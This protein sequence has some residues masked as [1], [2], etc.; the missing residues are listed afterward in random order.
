M[1]IAVAIAAVLDPKWPIELDGEGRPHVRPDR[2]ILS[3]FDESALEIALRLR[4]LD[5]ERVSISAIVTAEKIARAIAAFRIEDIAIL[6]LPF[7]ATCDA[8]ST[9]AALAGSLD[10]DADLVLIGR[11]FGDCD[12]GAVAPLLARL[13]DRPFFGR[14]QDVKAGAD[15]L[16]EGQ[17][18]EESV[19]LG[20]PILCS[21]TN[22]RR[23]RLRKPLMKNVMMARTAT[24]RAMRLV[25]AETPTFDGLNRVADARRPVACEMATGAPQAVAALLAARIRSVKAA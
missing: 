20:A 10:P 5:P 9:A 7:E 11:E 24:F 22:D 25:A 6:D 15:L 4:D 21:V 23:N 3:P 1:K 13:L 14:V 12:D 17:D 18:E 8:R 19:A 16:R 2:L